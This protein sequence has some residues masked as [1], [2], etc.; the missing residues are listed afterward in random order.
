LLENL[1]MV[2]F[3]RRDHDGLERWAEARAERLAGLRAP[4]V[5]QKGEW[6]NFVLYPGEPSDAGLMCW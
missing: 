6:G 3:N 1:Q 2:K 5:L 4:T